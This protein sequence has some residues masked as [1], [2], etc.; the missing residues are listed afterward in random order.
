MKKKDILRNFMITMLV[1]S[2]FVVLL[3]VLFYFTTRR[4]MINNMVSQAET[5]SNAIIRDV[6]SEL[7]NLYDTTYV[8]SRYDGVINMAYTSDTAG[9]YDHGE[10]V[11]ARSET[12]INKY[13]P[14][15]NAIVFRSDGMFYRIK[16]EISNTALKR[17]FYL[18]EKEQ[19]KIF[20]VTSGQTTYIGCMEKIISDEK[21][22][23][24]VVLLMERARLENLLFSYTDLD[25]LGTVIMSGNK[26]ISS[27]KNI[28]E[29]ELGETLNKS[30]FY[31][32]REIGLT[33]LNLIVYCENTVSDR[34]G[35]YFR[36]ALPFTIVVLLSVMALFVRYWRKHIIGPI[37]KII[38]NTNEDKD[39]PLP[40]TG[41]EY[42]DDLVE[43]VNDTLAR[44]EERDKELYYSR[45]RIKESELQT[46]R[47]L[48]SLLK[49]Q[50][51]AHFTVNTLNAIRALINKGEKEEA[52]KICNELSGLLRYAN[53]GAEFISLMEEF[54]VLEQYA[55]IMQTR[56]PN[57]FE[58]EV[59]ED[60][61][62]ID[63]MIPRMLLQPIV[64][65]AIIHGFVN[66][67][68]HVI[69]SADVTDKDVTISVSDDG[70][71]MSEKELSEVLDKIKNPEEPSDEDLRHV[72]LM[73]I[74]KRIKL[75]CGEEYGL[76][77]ESAK[78][79]GTTVKVKLP[80]SRP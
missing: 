5:T 9:F 75:L 63:I 68:G 53:A 40:L 3:W 6:E 51:G 20:T 42:F 70:K 16:G 8:L 36:I 66:N 58:F 32:E 35:R 34:L 14:A 24:Y 78:G 22:L 77:I 71:G 49:K 74:Q 19:N 54:H 21:S 12:I 13:C 23:G 60:D 62:F 27:N 17:A 61:S 37:N 55:S 79:E 11:A 50:I 1:L 56:Y 2:V 65:N 18:I 69:V 39:R 33:G 48:I 4:S 57:R 25:Y 72:A 47:T 59:E 52:S 30:V 41:E 43:H 76:S 29:D 44:I 26:I 64:E 15:D 31:K 28:T 7:L 45:I 38:R 80:V 10:Y 46:E 67:Q 73:N